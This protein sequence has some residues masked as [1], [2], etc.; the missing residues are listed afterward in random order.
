MNEWRAVD[1]Y[2]D[3]YM[4]SDNGEVKRCSGELLGQWENVLGYKLVRLSRP[5]KVMRV[6]RLVAEAFIPNS[7]NLPFVNHLDCEP[8]NNHV[9]NLEWCTQWENLNHSQKLGRMQRDHWKGRRSPNAHL[10]DSV[11]IQ[12]REEYQKGGVSWGFLGHKYNCSKRTIGRIINGEAY[13]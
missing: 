1:G 8:G 3:K 6:H 5:R 10:P 2:E 12:I 7:N 13:V 11:A 4:V 9:S